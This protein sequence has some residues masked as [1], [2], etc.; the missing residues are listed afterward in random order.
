MPPPTLPDGGDF[1]GDNLP[2]APA[3]VGGEGDRF[4]VNRDN[5]LQIRA[6]LIAAADDFRDWLVGNQDGLRMQPC[7]D[8][9]VSQDVARAVTYR[10]IDAEDSYFNVAMAHVNEAYR[11]ADALAETAR[12][13][14]YTEEEIES[15]LARGAEGL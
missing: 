11:T 5:V 8:D 13:Y 9:P 1:Y 10:T 14:G 15:G 3:P 7:G 4:S 12:G 6:Q 2:S